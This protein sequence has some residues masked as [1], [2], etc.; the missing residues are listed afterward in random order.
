[1]SPFR[2][3]LTVVQDKQEAPTILSRAK[4]LAC[5]EGRSASVH[6]VRVVYEGVADLKIKQIEGSRELKSFILGSEEAYLEDAIDAS[7]VL[8]EGIES[9]TL[10]NRNTWEGVLH[11]AQHVDADLIVKA[12]SDNS[13]IAAMI[14]TPDDWN[15]LRYTK[16]P[17]LMSCRQPWPWK[18]NIVAAV[19]VLD[20]KHKA[21]NARIAR[22][23]ASMA[24]QLGGNLHI[25]GSYPLF[26]PWA[27]Q[28][29]AASSYV[30]LKNEL[31]TDI[32]TCI[33]ELSETAAIEHYQAHSAEGSAVSAIRN[34]LA[35]IGGTLLVIG[36]N[37]RS[38]V[39]GA[40]LGNTAEKLLH[41]ATTD[42]LIVP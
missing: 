41:G 34:T 12:A 25:L 2:S 40:L 21:L 35:A 27:T 8:I 32:F 22:V 9:T 4:A 1:M 7:G 30:N 20:E 14:H 13:T 28:L 42:V 6:A 24:A 15:L 10:W 18:H 31:D 17:V 29:G 26:E 19:D 23:A 11:A 37:A 39:E 36:T 16:I 3:I 5:A 38:G 33:G